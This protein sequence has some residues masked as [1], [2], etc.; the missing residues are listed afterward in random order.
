MADGNM[1]L[2]RALAG[3]TL[4][5]NI[6]AG[7]GTNA[8]YSGGPSTSGPNALAG[9]TW[10]NIR[11]CSVLSCDLLGCGAQS[12]AL[13]LLAKHMLVG[14][15]IKGYRLCCLCVQP[16]CNQATQLE[17]GGGTVCVWASCQPGWRQLDPITG[18][19]WLKVA[20]HHP[21]H[22]DLRCVRAHKL[23]HPVQLCMPCPLL[24]AWLAEMCPSLH[25]IYVRRPAPCAQRGT[26]SA[27]LT[28]QATF[29]RRS[30][31][32]ACARQL[33]TANEAAHPLACSLKQPCWEDF[34]DVPLV[35]LSAHKR[36][37]FQQ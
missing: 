7:I 24:V 23:A 31:L 17:T 13:L 5:T 14:P 15:A 34:I 2:H 9:T 25:C 37:S 21:K 20:V 12:A 36:V 26:M 4:Y 11:R 19:C 29:T 8:L 28:S 18:M 6:D 27:L 22:S 35:S 3:P 33:Q 32:A 30:M 16:G 10:W 1:D